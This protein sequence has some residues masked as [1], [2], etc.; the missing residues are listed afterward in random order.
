MTDINKLYTEFATQIDKRATECMASV[1][2]C[3][4]IEQDLLHFLESESC[5]AVTMV[6][7]AKKLQANRRDRRQDKICLEQIQSIKSTIPSL[8]KKKNLT[9]FETKTY[10]Y[11][12]DVISQISHK[13][14]NIV[15]CKCKEG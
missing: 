10:M 3:D 15:R 12:S 9:S 2:E 7:I 11:K 5:D 13:P 8:V 4:R 1:A 14:K 6:M